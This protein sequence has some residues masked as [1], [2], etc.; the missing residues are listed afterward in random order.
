MVRFTF[1]FKYI[2]HA[3]AVRSTSVTGLVQCWVVDGNGLGFLAPQWNRQGQ[4]GYFTAN[5]S[6]AL[7]VA[8]DYCPGDELVELDMRVTKTDNAGCSKYPYVGA[9]RGYSCTNNDFKRGSFKYVYLPVLISPSHLLLQLR[10]LR[11]YKTIGSS[12]QRRKQLFRSHSSSIQVLQLWCTSSPL[13]S[14]ARS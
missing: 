10:L 3:N 11:R 12:R 2:F 6:A 13:F 7:G 1:H 8:F 4:Y 9:V 14:I 5:T